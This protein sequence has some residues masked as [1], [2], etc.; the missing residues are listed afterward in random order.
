[1]PISVSTLDRSLTRALENTSL[2]FGELAKKLP[3]I[4]GN[5]AL[6][7]CKTPPEI[8]TV[9]QANGE[10]EPLDFTDISSKHNLSVDEQG[11][12][13]LERIA[14]K[15]A[16]GLALGVKGGAGSPVVQEAAWEIA[17]HLGLKEYQDST[18][19]ALQEAGITAEEAPVHTTHISLSNSG[20]ID[21]TRTAQWDNAIDPDGNKLGTVKADWVMKDVSLVEAHFTLAHSFFAGREHEL[22]AD[23][24]IGLRVSDED[25]GADKTNLSVFLC[26]RRLAE[27]TVCLSKALTKQNS[28]LVHGGRPV[29]CRSHRFGKHVTQRQPEQ[30]DGG[31]VVGEVAAGLDDLA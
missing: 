21:L 15:I 10:S 13:I 19:G 17:A 3:D 12:Q 24:V 28:E 14:G 27:L 11:K 2:R 30:L 6:R 1:M 18:E 22:H 23:L 7:F 26:V 31:L 25:S 9:K 8:L 16:Q 20:A 4:H 29:E 5:L